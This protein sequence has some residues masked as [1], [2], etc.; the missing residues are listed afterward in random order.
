PT[1]RRCDRTPQTAWVNRGLCRRPV[2][3]ASATAKDRISRRIFA[4]FL[5]NHSAGKHLYNTARSAASAPVRRSR[6]Q[7]IPRFLEHR[8]KPCADAG[9]KL[10][11]PNFD[12]IFIKYFFDQ[13]DFAAEFLES[14]G[15]R[16]GNS[17]YLRIGRGEAQCRTPGDPHSLNRSLARGEIIR[18]WVSN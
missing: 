8:F 1:T 10:A 4:S 9:I 2:R 18:G 3:R 15:R 7:K 16:F 6:I 17:K 5:G 13:F 12:R 14:H 11:R